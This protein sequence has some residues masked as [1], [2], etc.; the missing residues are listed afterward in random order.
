MIAALKANGKDAKVR[1]AAAQWSLEAGQPDEAKTQAEAAVQLD[2]DSAANQLIRGMVAMVRKDFKTAEEAFA[3]AHLLAPGSFTPLS[4]LT[5][6]LAEQKEDAKK[7]LALDYAQVLTRL[8]PD[9]SDT[10]TT[11][12]W[13][14]YR[15]GRTDE[16]EVQLRRAVSSGTTLPDTLYFYAQL[17]ADR[18]QKDEARRLA[19]GALK[20]ARSSTPFLW[21]AQ[22]E[23]LV[24]QLKK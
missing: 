24:E 6:A 5:L 3:K 14:L 18:G 10:A 13:T 7:R 20:T 19:E 8:F 23:A 22:A 16:A 11:V 12:G 21:R 15:L 2:P 9:Q 4:N 1:R 17:L